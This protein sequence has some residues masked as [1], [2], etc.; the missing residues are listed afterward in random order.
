MSN[1]FALKYYPEF[2][3]L[4]LYL[5]SDSR[6]AALERACERLTA[7]CIENNVQ[8]AMARVNL[9]LGDF[10]VLDIFGIATH[11]AASIPGL[12][13]ALVFAEDESDDLKDF[14]QLAGLNR[15]LS[16]AFFSDSESASQWLRDSFN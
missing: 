4:S 11:L 16:I 1:P 9:P 5:E 13:L 12:N 15:G 8:R 7:A 6:S 3:E 2:V 10:S 14:F